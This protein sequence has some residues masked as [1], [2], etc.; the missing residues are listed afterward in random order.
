MIGTAGGDPIPGN[1]EFTLTMSNGVPLSLCVLVVGDTFASVPI[2]GAPGCNLYMGLP[3][4]ALFPVLSSATGYAEVAVPLPCSIPTGFA[5]VPT[6]SFAYRDVGC[7]A[8]L[9]ITQGTSSTTYSPGQF[10]TRAQ[11]AAFV[12]RLFNAVVD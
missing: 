3:F 4:V 2:P 11:M 5:D 12:E 7:I 10:V 1:D 8:A 6:S 9:G